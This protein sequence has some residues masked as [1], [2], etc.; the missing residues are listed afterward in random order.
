MDYLTCR[1]AE[2][3]IGVALLF[4]IVML[5]IYLEVGCSHEETTAEKYT[6]GRKRVQQRNIVYVHSNNSSGTATPQATAAAFSLRVPLACSPSQSLGR[7]CSMGI[8]HH[9]P[10]THI[11]ATYS[12]RVHRF[13]YTRFLSAEKNRRPLDANYILVATEKLYV[14]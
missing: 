11:C 9:V 14:I 7:S 10:G 8:M 13:T 1:R 5:L 6:L 12:E 4:Y 3:S 2:L